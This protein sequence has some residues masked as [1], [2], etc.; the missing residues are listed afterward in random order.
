MSVL[1]NRRDVPFELVFKYKLDRGYKIDKLEKKD[2][3]AFQ[4]FLDIVAEMT[5]DEVDKAYSRKPDK[6]DEYCG[7]QVYHY[8]VSYGFRIHV[9]IENGYYKIIRFDPNHRVHDK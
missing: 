8:E 1:T 6:K 7:N 4:K 3:K 2:L 5:V 9:V